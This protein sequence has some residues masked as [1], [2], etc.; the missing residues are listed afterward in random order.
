MTFLGEAPTLGGSY[1]FIGAGRDVE[2][3][4]VVTVYDTHEDSFATW[5]DLYFVSL[6]VVDAVEPPVVTSFIIEASYDPNHNSF[7]IIS[8]NEASGATVSLQHTD[9]LH[10]EWATL[11]SSDYTETVD[12]DAG[13]VIRTV[14]LELETNPQGFYRL[15]SE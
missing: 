12:T 10:E 3:G 14:I 8:R 15:I 13:T 4:L 9:S 1:I 11:D 2:S 7:S 5:P 6:N